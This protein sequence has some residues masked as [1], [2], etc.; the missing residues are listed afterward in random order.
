MNPVI[1]RLHQTLSLPTIT[2]EALAA[3]LPCQFEVRYSNG[4]PGNFLILQEIFEFKQGSEHLGVSCYGTIDG[5]ARR[6]TL[7]LQIHGTAYITFSQDHYDHVVANY[8]FA[9]QNAF[10]GVRVAQVWLTVS[11]GHFYWIEEY[12]DDFQKFWAAAGT[13]VHR[14][15][16]TDVLLLRNYQE[17][18]FNRYGFT[19]FDL[20]GTQN[21]DSFVLSDIELTNNC[22]H[23]GYSHTQ[24]TQAFRR[25]IIPAPTPTPPPPPLPSP[26]FPFF[27]ILTAGLIIFAII[28]FRN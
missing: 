13:Q 19:V 1:S 26:E 25:H 23:L 8:T 17:Y 28:Y 5:V 16:N 12:L 15:A 22:A 2:R 20:Q 10:P 6:F 7:R 27:P 3:Q 14:I 9:M 24:L 21:G 4:T 18:L 11:L